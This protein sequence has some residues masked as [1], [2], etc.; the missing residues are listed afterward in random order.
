M[1][2]MEKVGRNI[3][4]LRKKHNMTQMELADRMGISFQ[5]VSN[6][7]RGNSMP[8]ISK[9]PEL[10]ELFEVT[11]DELLGENAAIINSVVNGTIKELLE[12]NNNLVKDIS[13]IAPLLKPK[14]ANEI[15]E[16]VKDTNTLRDIEDLLPFISRDIVD[17]L[18]IKAAEEGNYHDLDI[19]AP[20]AGKKTLHDIA[21]RMLKENRSIA[22]LAPFLNRQMLSEY[23]EKNFL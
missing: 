20:F 5:A 15:F 4:E 17:A 13:K 23:V 2:Q 16:D 1:F 6:W 21:F 14:Q 22:N 8:D 7:E 18:M 3:S 11:I 10:A 12:N 9:L 19:L